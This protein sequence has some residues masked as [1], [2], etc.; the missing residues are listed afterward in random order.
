MD[1]NDIKL[2]VQQESLK[3]MIQT[4]FR[5]MENK[6]SEEFKLVRGDIATHGTANA[7][8]ETRVGVAE[9]EIDGLRKGSK[10]FDILDSVITALMGL[11]IYLSGK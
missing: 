9:D 2:A 8:L 4:E 1:D 6:M 3:T 10:V 11:G 7:V 5:T